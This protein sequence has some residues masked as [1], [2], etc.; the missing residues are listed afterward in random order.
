MVHD[1]VIMR[2]F[3]IVAAFCAFRRIVVVSLAALAP[4]FI[5]NKTSL[6][7]RPRDGSV[8]DDVLCCANFYRA[9]HYSAQRGIAI[10]CRLSVCLSVC[11][12]VT[13]VM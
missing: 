8:G 2:C 5:T 10:A 9:M 3:V 13:L 1:V 7:P 6:A 12:S 4:L 11:L